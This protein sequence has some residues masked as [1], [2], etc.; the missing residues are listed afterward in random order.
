MALLCLHQILLPLPQGYKTQTPFNGSYVK[1][2]LPDIPRSFNLE[3]QSSVKPFVS[4]CAFLGQTNPEFH[5]SVF[6][7]ERGGDC[8]IGM[9]RM[10][11][12]Y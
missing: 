1:V 11:V 9:S 2:K 5:C 12:L 8:N 3:Q 4:S 6:A 7:L 10:G